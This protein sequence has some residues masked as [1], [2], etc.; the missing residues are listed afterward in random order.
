MSKIQIQTKTP[1]LEISD[2][3]RDIWTFDI[4]KKHKADFEQVRKELA[5]FQERCKSA[6]VCRWYW[7]QSKGAGTLK[8]YLGH[9]E[10][11]MNPTTY[12]RYDNMYTKFNDWLAM[13]EKRFG[14]SSSF[15]EA[16]ANSENTRYEWEPDY[17]RIIDFLEPLP[18]LQGIDFNNTVRDITND[19]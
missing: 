5:V 10:F 3:D 17:H 16:Y 1:Q 2:W 19:F 15:E 13:E 18:E 8:L 11:Y 4:Y 9:V 7:L 14:L 6:V 12:K